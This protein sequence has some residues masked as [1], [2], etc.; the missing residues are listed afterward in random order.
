MARTIQSPGVEIKEVDLSLRPQLP[1]GT[2]VFATG[3]AARGPTEEIIQVSSLS[4]FEQI[5]GKPSNAA[6]RYFYH[7]VKGIFQSQANVLLSRLPYGSG[8]GDTSADKYSA[9]VY[10]VVALSGSMDGTGQHLQGA[11]GG[12]VGDGLQGQTFKL[13]ADAIQ[14]FTLSAA[15]TYYIAP[16]STVSLTESEYQKLIDGQFTWDNSAKTCADTWAKSI[17]AMHAVP[18]PLS[19]LD[20]IGKSAIIVLNKRKNTI[21]ERFEGQYIGLKDNTNLNPASD[22]DSIVGIKSLNKN[23]ARNLNGGGGFVP[24][25]PFNNGESQY[26]GEYVSIPESRLTFAL[27]ATGQ[28]GSVGSVAEDMEDIF[29]GDSDFGSDEYSDI[30]TL[31]VF[32]LRQSTLDPDVVKLDKILLESYT[33][34]LNYF[35]ELPK[36]DGTP[37]ASKF[38]ENETLAS[39]NIKILVNPYISK[40]G[41]DWLDD[42]GKPTKRVRMMT[43]QSVSDVHSF[44]NTAEQTQLSGAREYLS[45]SSNANRSESRSLYPAG[46][47]KEASVLGGQV[48]SIP[49]K[50][51][52]VFE[53]VDNHELYPIDITVDGGLSTIWAGSSGGKIKFD[54][55]AY[56][57]IGDATEGTGLYQTKIIGT[58]D[59]VAGDTIANYREVTNRFVDFSANKRKDNIF[60]SDPLRYVFVQGSN[61]KV[62]SDKAKNFSQHVYWPLKHTYNTINTSYA[63]AYA[64]W[65]KVFDESVSKQVWL[66]LSGKIAALYANTDSNF[67]PWIAPAGFSRGVLNTV[68]DIALYPKQKHRDQLYKIRLNPIANFPNDGFVVYGQKTMQTKPSAFDRVNVRRLFLNLEKATRSTVKY[69]VFE[70]NT[71]FTRTQVV[72]VLTPIFDRAKQTEGLY[73]Y[74]II[75]DERN[76]TPSV[77]DQNE[78]VVDIYLKPVR[79]SEFILVNFYATRTGQ[80]FS[81]ILS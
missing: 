75:C 22:Y 41:G 33:G 37:S 11:S 44:L 21:N 40:Y 43:N 57:D 63:A 27:S 24:G 64:N 12:I 77:I 62:L 13:L 58:D 74:I 30:I 51:D 10:P 81:E 4:E 15:D 60:I 71:L 56:F 53:L 6:E 78:L 34:S 72:N 2:S 42:K 19:S 65:G 8:A 68:N 73:D 76:N 32:K 23:N 17:S 45:Y 80:D 5:Y 26:E 61:S 66:P 25:H 39:N 29:G 59:A 35:R 46:V 28:K 69:F 48:G 36:Q 50:L 67:Q 18:N 49:S 79:A 20:H 47:F 16:P 70:P 1:A 38:L 3:F 55:E 31:G 14:D 9:L 54:D 7:T 52:N